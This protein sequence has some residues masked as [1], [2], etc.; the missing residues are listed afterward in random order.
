[1]AKDR[2]KKTSRRLPEIL[3]VSDIEETQSWAFYGRPGTGKT[4]LAA[5]WPKPALL[6]DFNDRGTKSVRNIKGLKVA[7][8]ED[9][10]EV[11]AIF[12][13][14][15]KG[16][17]RFKTV[18][19]DTVTQYQAMAIAELTGKR[20][21][22]KWGA[23]TRAQYGTLAGQL[24]MSFEDFRD[25]PMEVI[26]LAQERIFNLGD[27]EE[28][29]ANEIQPSIGSRLMPSVADALHAAV[30]VVAQ[31]YIRH[32]VKKTK[33]GSKIH[34][35]DIVEYCL[36]VGPHPVKTSKIRKPKTKVPLSFLV[37]P[38]YADLMEIIEGEK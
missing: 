9:V 1:M 26:F 27:E 21:N 6:L 18:I 14:L 17:H 22:A 30:N 28:N 2:D 33:E 37:D 31:T 12:W 13:M 24:K 15:K 34:R 32:R 7:R 23:L 8:I 4:T 29:G 3:D 20:D 38:T 11:E 19:F 25:L 16:D 35:K 10:E 5:S 36:Y